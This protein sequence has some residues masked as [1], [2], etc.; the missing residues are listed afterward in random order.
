[1]TRVWVGV[2]AGMEVETFAAVVVS[3][4]PPLEHGSLLGTVA[5]CFLRGCPVGP[6]IGAWGASSR[7]VLAV[8]VVFAERRACRLQGRKGVLM[9]LEDGKQGRRWRMPE[10]FWSEEGDDSTSP[11]E[12]SKAGSRVQNHV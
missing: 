5:E 10:V 11:S 8:F 9:L 3:L 6:P 7:K 12:R 1:M 2:A 4:G